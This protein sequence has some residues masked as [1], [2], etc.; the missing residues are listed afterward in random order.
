MER[1]ITLSYNRRNTIC[2]CITSAEPSESVVEA[3]SKDED[4]VKDDPVSK[5]VETC[6]VKPCTDI[7]QTELS[8]P[9]DIVKYGSTANT[10]TSKSLAS[11]AVEGDCTIAVKEVETVEKYRSADIHGMN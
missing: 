7:G 6:D 11:L 1:K 5:V 9:W 4:F 2:C 10:D 3:F 8:L